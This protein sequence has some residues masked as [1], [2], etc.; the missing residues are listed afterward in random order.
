MDE[1]LKEASEK[2]FKALGFN[3]STA[4]TAFIKQAVREQRI[5]FE[6]SLNVPGGE[7]IEALLE[8][9][10]LLHDSNAKRFSNMEDLIKD[11]ENEV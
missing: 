1:E 10:K 6:I 8:S 4:I 2:L 5:P 11:L 7:T 3:M 9:E